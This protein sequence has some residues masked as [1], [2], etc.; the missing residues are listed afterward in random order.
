MN[1]AGWEIKKATCLRQFDDK[2][3]LG[4]AAACDMPP[5]PI[6]EKGDGGGAT[7]MKNRHCP[8]KKP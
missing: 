6:W 8:D 4:Q 3:P 5:P 2:L 7:A 1:G